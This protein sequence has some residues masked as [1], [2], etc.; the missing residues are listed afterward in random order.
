MS[1]AIFGP[2]RLWLDKAAIS[3]SVT[4]ALHCVLLPVGL[5]LVPSI[6]SLPFG[7]ENFHRGLV[8]LVLPMS[9][10]ALTLGC[11]RHRQWSAFCV[12]VVGVSILLATALYGHD[13]MGESLEKTTTVIGSSLVIVGHLLNFRRCRE[14]D[15]QH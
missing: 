13:L 1:R 15:C 2:Q 7:D 4:C 8:F 9:L 3:L 10:V 14:V 5:V 6:A 12:G 11:R